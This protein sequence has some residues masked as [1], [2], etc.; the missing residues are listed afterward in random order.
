MI[1]FK[2]GSNESFSLSQELISISYQ[3]VGV[4]IEYERVK[5]YLAVDEFNI[6]PYYFVVTI[7]TERLIR[8]KDAY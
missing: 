5:E 8:D 4:D 6:D 2:L 3:I 7:H 1:Q